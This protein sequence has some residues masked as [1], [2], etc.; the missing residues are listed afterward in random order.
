MTTY[1]IDPRRQPQPADGN[2]APRGS[3]AEAREQ[4]EEI[5]DE[6]AARTPKPPWVSERRHDALLD[7]QVQNMTIARRIDAEIAL[8]ERRRENHPI[9]DYDPLSWSLAYGSGYDPLP[10]D[11]GP[12]GW[13]NWGSDMPRERPRQTPVLAHEHAWYSRK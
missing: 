10:V 13:D 4:R 2:A 11:V 6:L 7:E 8:T 3:S 1:G 12:M 5:R 9:V